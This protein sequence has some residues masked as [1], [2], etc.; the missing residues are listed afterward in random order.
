MSLKNKPNSGRIWVASPAGGLA[1]LDL[2][3]TQ[4]GLLTR[5]YEAN[6]FRGQYAEPNIR[7]PGQ[8]GRSFNCQ[9]LIVKV[10]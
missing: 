7:A 5:L 4:Y 2:T 3:A 9:Q 10:K 6:K 8:K 1:Y